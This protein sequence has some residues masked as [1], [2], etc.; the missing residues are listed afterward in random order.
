MGRPRRPRRR[1]RLR[2]RC[3]RKDCCRRRRPPGTPSRC[4][5]WGR[6]GTPRG[7]LGCHTGVRHP[8]G[9]APRSR[10]SPQGTAGYP[11]GSPAATGPKLKKNGKASRPYAATRRSPRAATTPRGRRAPSDP[12]GRPSHPFA[13]TTTMSDTCRTLCPTIRQRGS[14]PDPRSPRCKMQ[15]RAGGSTRRFPPPRHA[16]RVDGASRSRCTCNRCCSP[17]CGPGT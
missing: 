3:C 15:S 2:L 13:T 1:G 16:A 12:S 4:A 17:R 14:A 6:G 11:R 8:G 5:P 9:S 10:R 7:P